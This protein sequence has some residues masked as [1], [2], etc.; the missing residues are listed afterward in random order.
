MELKEALNKALDFE[1]KGH[2]IYEE[3]AKKT[4][5][6]IVAETFSYLA[7]QELSHIQGIKDYLEN[8]QIELGG[9]A[10]SHTKEFFTMTVK[11]FRKKTALSKDDIK[12]HETALELEKSSY[13]FYKKQNISTKDEEL[14]KFFS[15]LMDQENAH[16][17][18]I[19]KAYEFI[20]NPTAFYTEEEGW[21]ADGG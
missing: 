19:Q 11:E 14:K 7:D 9:E 1:Q 17:E 16:Y 3:I 5:N 21:M 12:A 13:E 6:Q 2:D 18:L 10:P 4:K 15:V 20:K 8:N